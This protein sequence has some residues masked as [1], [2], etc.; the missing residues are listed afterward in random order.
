MN[1]AHP[2]PPDKGT[3]VRHGIFGAGAVFPCVCPAKPMNPFPALLT[4]ILMEGMH[5]QT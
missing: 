1:F 5:M 3:T 2:S 4:L